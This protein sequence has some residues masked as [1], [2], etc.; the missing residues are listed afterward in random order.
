MRATRVALLMVWC[1]GAAWT[2][3]NAQTFDRAWIDI[4]FASAFPAQDEQFYQ[5]QGVLFAELATFETA[6]PSMPRASGPIAGGGVRLFGGLGVG[7]NFSR[8]KYE[9][10]VQLGISIPHPTLPSRFATDVDETA[11]PLEREDAAFDISA[12]YQLPTPDTWRVRVFGGPTYFSLSQEMVQDINYDQAAN[13]AGANAVNITSFVSEKVE[14]S[15]W[16]FHAG[17][18]VGYYFS[19]HVG[20][21]GVFR[22][23]RGTIT[24]PFEPMSEEPADI[25]MGAAMFGGGLR[26]RF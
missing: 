15:G 21:G 24:I 12:A 10:P 25:K 6:Y 23:N 16:G 11:N 7:V 20:V 5:F 14:D 4:N 13:A 19:R 9:Y 17:V 8:V 26:L 22:F 2:A 18:D 3:A 1:L